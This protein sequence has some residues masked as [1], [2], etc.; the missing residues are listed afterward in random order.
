MNND[1]Q[2]DSLI[3]QMAQEHQL[4]LPSP[5]VIWWRAQIQ[6]KIADKERIERPLV[7]MRQL[8]AVVWVVAFLFLLVAYGRTGSALFP[9]FAAVAVVVLIGALAAGLRSSKT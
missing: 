2:L 1:V 9:L 5:G 6:K 8:T 4:E 3:K 7:I